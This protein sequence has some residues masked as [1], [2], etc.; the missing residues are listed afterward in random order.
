MKSGL[1]PRE[2]ISG[3][4]TILEPLTYQYDNNYIISFGSR[5]SFNNSL[6]LILF[7][8]ARLKSFPRH[9]QCVSLILGYFLLFVFENIFQ[10]FFIVLF[11]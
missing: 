10:T 7:I 2:F 9:N 5:G 4:T 8:C 6:S 1:R 11:K 3:W